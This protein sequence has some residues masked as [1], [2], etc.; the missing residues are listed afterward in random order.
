MSFYEEIYAAVK[1]I[2][3]GNVATYGQIAAA[4]GKPRAPRAVGWALHLNPDPS[5]IPCHRV[6]M[7]DGG[8]SKAFAF[9][10]EQEQMRRL[11]AEGI[12]FIDG[13]VDMPRYRVRRD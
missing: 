4:C 1:A 11:A 7:K 10:G 3:R 2:P 6:V 13:K 8:L 5:E 12:T 9:G